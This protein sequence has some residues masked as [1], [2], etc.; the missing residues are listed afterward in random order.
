MKIAALALGKQRVSDHV[1][2]NLHLITL[3]LYCVLAID[4]VI[5]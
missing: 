1:T 2:D 4:Q 3:T 5:F